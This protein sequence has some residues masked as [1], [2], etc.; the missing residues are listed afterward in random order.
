VLTKCRRTSL[1]VQAGLL[2]ALCLTGFS[3]AS[4]YSSVTPHTAKLRDADVAVEEVILFSHAA[5]SMGPAVYVSGRYHS[6][7]NVTFGY[8][9]LAPMSGP[10]CGGGTMA[11]ALVLHA[12]GMQAGTIAA[13]G[14][15]AASFVRSA[16]VLREPTAL[17]IPIRYA[18]GA[19]GICLRVPV[20][21][22]RGDVQWARLPSYSWGFGFQVLVPF[23]RIYDVAAVPQLSFRAGPWIGPFRIRADLALGGAAARA[24][25]PNLVGYAFGG[26]ILADT[27]MLSV[28]Q[29]GLGVAAG[30]DVTAITFDANVRALS[31]DGAGYRGLIHGPRG[32]LLFELLGEPAI[33]PAFK[34]RRDSESATLEVFGEAAWSR[35]HASATPAI[36]IALSVDAGNF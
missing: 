22:G 21:E 32:G 18:N 1:G 12:E 34:R 36:W 10:P 26:G 20:V 15:F 31:N 27:L 5:T 19:A 9:Q 33:E 16:T 6:E 13:S 3:C 23:R 25:N 24:R 30:Y 11:S 17:D 14:T 8:P 2:V 28:G 7:P 4:A 35:D 29:F